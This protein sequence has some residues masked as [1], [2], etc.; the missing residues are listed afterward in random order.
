MCL[1]HILS[2]LRAAFSVMHSAWL[3]L[4]RMQISPQLGGQGVLS[5]RPSLVQCLRQESY[6]VSSQNQNVQLGQ[7]GVRWD[8]GQSRLW[9]EDHISLQLSTHS[10]ESISLLFQRTQ[11]IHVI[12]FCVTFR[13]SVCEELFQELCLHN[14]EK[15]GSLLLSHQL[16]SSGGGT[17][18]PSSPMISDGRTI[19][20]LYLNCTTILLHW[21]GNLCASK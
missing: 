4:N 17:L 19:E 5:L 15:N 13:N 11:T 21:K 2:S 8:W 14:F 12:A 3:H 1:S 7:F 10:T 16:F 18:L 20:I 9:T 6:V